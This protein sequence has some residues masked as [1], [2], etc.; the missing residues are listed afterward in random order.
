MPGSLPRRVRCLSLILDAWPDR[1]AAVEE[2]KKS[3]LDE[4]DETTTERFLSHLLRFLLDGCKAKDKN[5]RFRVCQCI[6]DTIDHYGSIECV[7]RRMVGTG[8]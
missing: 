1:P 7:P 2:R 8:S 5:V 4:D 6:A 3:G